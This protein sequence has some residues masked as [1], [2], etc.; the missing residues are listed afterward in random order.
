[1][2]KKRLSNEEKEI[3]IKEFQ[4]TDSTKVQFCKKHKIGVTNFNDWIRQ[5][6]EHTAVEFVQLENNVT[7]NSKHEEVAQKSI[8]LEVGSIKIILPE[9]TSA[10]F[11][12]NL[13]KEVVNV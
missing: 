4:N 1:M 10:I 12:G 11:L 13:I 5:S 2:A 9:G 8:R 3:L 7:T 6:K